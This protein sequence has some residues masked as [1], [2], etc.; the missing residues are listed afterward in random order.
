MIDRLVEIP[1]V[2]ERLRP[3]GP[4]RPSGSDG[5]R[6]QV[7]LGFDKPVGPF[8]GE[9]SG[10]FFIVRRCRAAS[11]RA[12]MPAGAMGV[13]GNLLPVCYSGRD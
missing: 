3:Y 7:T 13:S 9:A 5:S 2:A 11:R 12:R 8:A 10:S 1:A 6:Q 4:V